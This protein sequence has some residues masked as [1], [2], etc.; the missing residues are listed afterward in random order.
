[1]CYKTGH[2]IYSPHYFPVPVDKLYLRY[3]LFGGEFIKDIFTMEV[4]MKRSECSSVV[5]GVLIAL[6]AFTSM[7]W[8]K[9]D[10][11]KTNE[12]GVI[13]LSFKS[14]EPA[15]KDVAPEVVPAVVKRYDPSIDTYYLYYN[16]DA[17]PDITACGEN[18]STGQVTC[19]IYNPLTG[20]VL[21]TVNILDG[22]YDLNPYSVWF[23]DVNGDSK[24]DAVGCGVKLSD[25]SVVCQIKTVSTGA[26]VKQFTAIPAN[27]IGYG[28]L[29]YYDFRISFGYPH[30]SVRYLQAS[31]QQIYFK[32]VN[33]LTGATVVAPIPA[34]NKFYDASLY[35][36]DY[37]NINGVAGNELVTCARNHMSGQFV[38]EIKNGTTGALIKNI[39]LLGTSD[40]MQTWGF[41]TN[42]DT[43]SAV[44][45]FIGCGWLVT[46]RQPRCQ[47]KKQ[48]NTQFKLFNIL[49]PTFVP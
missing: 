7:S 1:M 28:T 49:D 17:V 13:T 21:A 44:D 41:D 26:V 39:T 38:C 6:F 25:H 3:K 11:K 32:T 19:K 5:V 24:I 8:A 35:S 20:G 34:L 16:A 23:T 40:T 4:I 22:S 37:T 47:I 12:N 29:W 9:M 15:S 27:T 31:N 2:I 30:W 14:V 10:V 48:D 33:P 42:Y 45:E 43:L 46:T 18:Q 36:P